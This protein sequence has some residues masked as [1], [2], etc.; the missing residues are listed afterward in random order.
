[1]YRKKFTVTKD[2]TALAMGS[3]SLQVL[4]T[5]ALIA[6]A[7]N[8]CAELIAQ[9]LSADDTTVGTQI[10][11]KHLKA[12]GLDQ[13]IDISVKLIQSTGK[14]YEFSFQAFEGE[15][16]IGEGNHTRVKVNREKFLRHV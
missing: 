6:F 3:G 5:P 9:E 11:C 4:A 7:E 12:T 13:E 16:L 10:N 15:I 14:K 2:W 1:M 8:T